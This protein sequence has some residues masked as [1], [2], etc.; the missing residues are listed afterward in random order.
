M[1]LCQM[2]RRLN[3]P[4][5]SLYDL[6]KVVRKFFDFTLVLKESAKSSLVCSTPPSYEFAYQIVEKAESE[7][8]LSF[9][10]D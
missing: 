5:S 6:L 8:L 3:I 1:S 7:V 9:P 4:V 2:S 10:M